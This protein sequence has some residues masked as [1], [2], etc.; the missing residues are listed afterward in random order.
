MSLSSELGSVWERHVL[1]LT[2]RSSA[3]GEVAPSVLLLIKMKVLGGEK[4]AAVPMPPAEID[5][6]RH[7]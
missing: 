6:Q 3:F 5:F 4:R 7:L 2:D 1:L